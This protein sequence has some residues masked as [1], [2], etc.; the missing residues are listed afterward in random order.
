MQAKDC[1]ILNWSFSVLYIR[2]G[3]EDFMWADD[4]KYLILCRST[5]VSEAHIIM[6]CH[7]SSFPS[8]RRADFSK[9]KEHNCSNLKA[10]SWKAFTKGRYR[11]IQSHNPFPLFF[12]HLEMFLHFFIAWIQVIQTQDRNNGRVID[13]QLRLNESVPLT[14][15]IHL[16]LHMVTFNMRP[17][18]VLG[19]QWD[20]TC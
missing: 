6:S 13:V 1:Q 17:N 5:V 12:H 20:L 15:C 14:I 8:K 7:C 9:T 10:Y 19:D 18:T 4:S 16:R 2:G 3:K 11:E